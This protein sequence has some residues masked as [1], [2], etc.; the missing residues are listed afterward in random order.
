MQALV[1]KEFNMR[2]DEFYNPEKDR[3]ASRSIDDVR[4]TKLTLETL[5]KLRKYREIKKSETI[6]QKK[7]ASLMYAKQAQADTGGF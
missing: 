6:E 7:F 4:K 3:S 2:L 5:N 1:S